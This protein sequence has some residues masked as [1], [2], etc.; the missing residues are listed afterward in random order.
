MAKKYNLV[1]PDVHRLGQLHVVRFDTSEE[2]LDYLK[3]WYPSAMAISLFPLL[4][5]ERRQ[6]FE[7]ETDAPLICMTCLTPQE[8]EG[9]TDP[10]NMALVEGDVDRCGRC[11]TLFMSKGWRS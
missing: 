7:L 2:A 5:V 9:L 8:R 11:Q 4:R 1:L 3:Q 10:D 6:L